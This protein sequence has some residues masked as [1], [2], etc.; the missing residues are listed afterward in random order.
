MPLAEGGLRC[1]QSSIAPRPRTRRFR[2]PRPR[3]R[4][5]R[6]HDGGP[7]ASYSAATRRPDYSSPV[8]SSQSFRVLSYFRV[9]VRIVAS[10]STEHGGQQVFPPR[11]PGAKRCTP[12]CGQANEHRP[13]TTLYLIDLA[14]YPACP[15]VARDSRRTDRRDTLPLGSREWWRRSKA[16]AR[17]ASAA[18]SLGS[19]ERRP[20]LWL[21]ASAGGSVSDTWCLR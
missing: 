2:I 13:R 15:L 18:T 8:N 16:V 5:E 19:F 4:R 21:A 9:W 7:R 11:R 6:S 1:G 10:V 20:G 17:S 3:Y 12:V 14:S